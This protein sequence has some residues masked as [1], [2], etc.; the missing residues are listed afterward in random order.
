MPASVR[1]GHVTV[2]MPN[3]NHGHYIA[4][5]LTQICTQSRAPDRV[6]VIDDASTDNSRDVIRAMA[7][8]F[9]VIEVQENPVARGTNANLN[10]WALRAD[11]EYLFFAAADDLILPGFLEKS[12][13][14]L[15]RHPTAAYSTAASMQIDADGRPLPTQPPAPSSPDCHLTP[16]GV[17]ALLKAHGSFGWGN[18]MIYRRDF[19][20][21]ATG[22]LDEALEAFADGYMLQAKGLRHGCIYIPEVLGQWRVNTTGNAGAMTRS[23][24]RMK[25]IEAEILRRI[26]GEDR[27]VFPPAYRDLFLRRW[28]YSAALP[29]LN[30]GN[31]SAAAELAHLGPVATAT[32]RIIATRLGAP[33]ATRALFL[34]LLPDD[35][36]R[37]IARKLGL[38]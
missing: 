7:A 25:R 38:R 32:L 20:L 3:R 17:L 33:W 5:A 1:R 19:F 12:L 23:F 16:D 9:P 6:V 24:E 36:L 37:L 31:S 22:V 18:T 21:T 30:T 11:T 27:D 34:R 4:G 13:T 8:Q 15:D 35:A 29:Q 14:C 10:D 28:Y 2:V 26:N